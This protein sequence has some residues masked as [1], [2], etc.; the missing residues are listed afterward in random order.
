MG[1]LS[2]I[3]GGSK[4]KTK[5]S[6]T[7]TSNTASSSFGSNSYDRT[8][9]PVIPDWMSTGAQ[10]L[11]RRFAQLGG[12][13]P[14]SLVAG[15]HA[16]EADAAASLGLEDFDQGLYGKLLTG[17]S[18]QVGSESLLSGLNSYMSPY[19]QQVVDSAMA[20]FDADAGRTRATQTLQLAGAGAFGGSGAALTR[21]FTENE[22][23]RARN[24]QLSGL[25]DQ[26]FNRGATLA[27]Q[28]ADR[29][30][31]ASLANAQLYQQDAQRRASMMFDHAAMGR[32][33]A[34]LKGQLGAQLR[35]VEQTQRQ[36][37]LDLAAW[38]ADQF[39]GLPLQL[40]P[41]QRQ[42]GTETQSQNQNSSSTGT[43]NGTSKTSG[44]N[45]SISGGK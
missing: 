16:L 34:E 39:S 1:I 23:S 25:L 38:Q 13:D 40:F 18:P 32:A 11:N 33:Q 28:D 14:Q 17:G 45:F 7:T 6:N 22:L 43:E 29:R 24:T 19:R 41:G 2:A 35:G 37:P 21:S 27:N 15:P 42:T 10:D 20:D 3:F 5:T 30:Q 4:S 31:A 8:T 12:A 44:F 9:A 26:M 36:A